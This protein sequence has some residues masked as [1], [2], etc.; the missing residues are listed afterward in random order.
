MSSKW[1]EK[2]DADWQLGGSLRDKT[3]TLVE[4]R[5]E[6]AVWKRSSTSTEQSDAAGK[7]KRGP[8]RQQLAFVCRQ[9][10][11][12]ADWESLEEKKEWIVQQ[13]EEMKATQSLD[14][15][16]VGQRKRRSGRA[17]Q[18]HQAATLEVRSALDRTRREKS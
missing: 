5:R 3:E 17:A 7:V 11:W 14:G 9:P 13:E 18:N 10:W 15:Q 1:L 8:V 6:A 12:R 4:A 2:V 16:N